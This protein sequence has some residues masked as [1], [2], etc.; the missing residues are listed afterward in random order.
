MLTQL[1][2]SVKEEMVWVHSLNLRFVSIVIIRQTPF[3]ES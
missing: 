3:S 1:T 2:A